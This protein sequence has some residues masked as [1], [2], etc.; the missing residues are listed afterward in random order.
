MPLDF[1]AF[2][3]YLHQFNKHVS[4]FLNS[5]LQTGNSNIFVLR[6]VIYV[7]HFQIKSSFPSEKIPEV[8]LGT[9]VCRKAVKI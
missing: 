2:C 1:V 5:I 4:D 6:V 7:K 8:E 3:F 9:H